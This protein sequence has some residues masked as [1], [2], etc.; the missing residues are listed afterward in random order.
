M[1]RPLTG[2]Y[3]FFGRNRQRPQSHH[4]PA[5]LLFPPVGELLSQ[6]PKV[7][8]CLL[9]K[10]TQLQL[11]KVTHCLLLKVTYRL[12]CKETYS[13]SLKVADSLLKV[14]HCLLQKVMHYQPLKVAHCLPLKKRSL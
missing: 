9:L 2:C 1:L 5:K 4:T 11:I 12:P 10:V 3:S 14:T 7:T 8:H 13:L 6:S